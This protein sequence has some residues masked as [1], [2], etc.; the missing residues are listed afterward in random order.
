MLGEGVDAKGSF[1]DLTPRLTSFCHRH[2]KVSFSYRISSYCRF[3]SAFRRW[4]SGLFGL[5]L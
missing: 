1:G 5:L 3:A 4:T 2:L